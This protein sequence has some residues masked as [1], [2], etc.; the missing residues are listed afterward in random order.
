M[1]GK[2]VTVSLSKQFTHSKCGKKT[3][4]FRVNQWS[5]VKNVEYFTN[6]VEYNMPVDKL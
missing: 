3:L 5:N 1:A 4:K 2:K 6:C